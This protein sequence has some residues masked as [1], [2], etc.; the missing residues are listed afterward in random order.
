MAGEP[1][2][3][4]VA[5]LGSVN[6]DLV[7]HCAQLPAPGETVT[8]SSFAEIPGGKGAN[9]AV[10]AARAGGHV[11]MIGR[12]GDDGFAA[13]LRK[14]LEV[15]EIDCRYLVSTPKSASG[16]A[17]IGVEDSGE[18]Q[19]LVV[20]GANGCVSKQDV[21]DAKVCI[22]AADILLLQ[23]EIPMATVE[24][25]IQTARELGTRVVVDP[26]PAPN[27]PTRELFGVDL[28]CPN[29]SEAA[30]LTAMPVESISQ[31]EA[32]A[33]HLHQLGAKAV[34]ITLGARGTALYADGK[35]SLVSAFETSVVDT[36]AAGDAFAGALAVRWAETGALEAAVEFGNAAGAIAASRRGAQPGMG[37]REDILAR[38]TG[39]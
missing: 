22:A 9:Q 1:D 18:N 7:A 23:L 38:L 34:A 32:A 4:R 31:I 14:N 39:R 12:V 6:M 36:T 21:E 15:E 33:K 3:A 29:E 10:S 16:V 17:M 35:F 11:E 26:A 37:S 8:A 24:F 13:R 28:I 27:N 25:A 5:V 2:K 20:P 30:A 19:I